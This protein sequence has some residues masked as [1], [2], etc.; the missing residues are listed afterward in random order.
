[1]SNT[2]TQQVKKQITIMLTSGRSIVLSD[3]MS[4]ETYKKIIDQVEDVVNNTDSVDNE[5]SLEFTTDTDK[6]YIH[7]RHVSFI[8][9]KKKV[10]H[11]P[12]LY[13]YEIVLHLVNG[14]TI[15]F[16]NEEVDENIQKYQDLIDVGMKFHSTKPFIVL[17][18]INETL[19]IN[20]DK[21]C[22]GVIR[23]RNIDHGGT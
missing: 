23:K 9:M 11:N 22:S 1:M 16:S 3:N 17:P 15:I 7:H 21:L 12:N 13:K 20:N 8:G 19:F 2:N 5:R 4:D 18:S 6:V 14:K 10:A